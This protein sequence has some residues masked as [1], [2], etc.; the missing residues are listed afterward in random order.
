MAARHL[1]YWL[2]LICSLLASPVLVCAQGASPQANAA[3]LGEYVFTVPPGWMPQQYPDGIVLSAPL[4]NINE[5]CLIQIWPMRPTSGNL[6]SDAN[7]SFAEIFR[8]YEVRYQTSRGTALPPMAIHG[9]SGQGWEYLIIKRGIRHPGFAP[10]GQPWETLLGFV[11]VAKLNS[12]V[13]VISGLSRDSLVSNCFG[14]LGTNVWP[15][16]FYALSFKGWQPGDQTQIMRKL[17]AGEWIA[18]T[19]TA[20]DKITFAGNGRFA[21]AA[22]AQQYHLTTNELIT[23]TQAYFGN[24]SYTLRGTRSR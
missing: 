20:G 13:A 11:F 22:A 17:L 6:L 12:R 21:N 3:S 8:T 18:A 23:T 4:S 14:E 7:S 24:G 1:R 16:F 10:N 9:L 2:C 15:R 5:R 19:A